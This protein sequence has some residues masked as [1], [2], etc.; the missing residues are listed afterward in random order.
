MSRSRTTIM[1]AH[2]LSTIV[3]A[4]Q[5]VVLDEGRVAERGTH[6]QLLDLGGLYAELWY[7]QAAERLAEETAE[8]AE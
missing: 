4:D 3:E 7:R 5:I 2:R 1:I 8:A 6:E